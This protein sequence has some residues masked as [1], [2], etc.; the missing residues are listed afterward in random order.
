MMDDTNRNQ[1]YAFGSN[2]ISGRPLRMVKTVGIVG[3]TEGRHLNNTGFLN[4][5][6]GWRQ[7]I[8]ALGLF[9]RAFVE[10]ELR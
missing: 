7:L 1:L 8:I 9:F 5:T 4:H 3:C 2:N 10:T 6:A